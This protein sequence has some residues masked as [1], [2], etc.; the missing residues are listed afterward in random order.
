MISTNSGVAPEYNMQLLVAKK[1]MGVVI[2]ISFFFHPNA[3]PNKCKAAV[4]L[5]SATQCLE[6]NFFES[7]LSNF[8]TS[9]PCVIKLFFKTFV[10][11]LISD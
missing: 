8:P 4:P 7:N 10:T 2:I 3:K 6:P 1:E 9:C 11:A 5:D